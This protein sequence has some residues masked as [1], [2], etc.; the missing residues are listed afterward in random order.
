MEASYLKSELLPPFL[1]LAMDDSEAVRSSV[2]DAALSLAKGLSAEDAMS[3]LTTTVANCADD[4]NWKIRSSF[5]KN[6]S[7]FATAFGSKHS[8]K[9]LL[10]HF[11]IVM[12]DSEA[13]VRTEAVNQLPVVAAITDVAVVSDQLLGAAKEIVF[14]SNQS[15]RTALAVKLPLLAPILGK[16]KCVSQLMPMLTDL[17]KDEV[18][19]VRLSVVNSMEPLNDVVGSDLM[20]TPLMNAIVKLQEDRQ[21]RVRLAVIEKMPRLAKSLGKEFFDEKLKPLFI[22]SLADSVF[23]IREATVKNLAPLTAVFGV[24]WCKN[25]LMT[26]IKEIPEKKNTSLTRMTALYSVSTLAA[27]VGASV[28]TELLLPTALLYAKDTVPNVRFLAAKTL[29]ELAKVVDASVVSDRISPMLKEMESD[30]DPDVKHFAMMSLKI[31]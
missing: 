5:A 23:A 26:A 10:K 11:I 13:D 27:A 22:S 28:A 15:V 18:S 20:N 9:M 24:D 17:V 31:C 30:A 8:E 29:G 7:A 19:D 3:L 2:V 14:D 16:D 1:A 4:K 25:N 6:Y 12:K 21:W